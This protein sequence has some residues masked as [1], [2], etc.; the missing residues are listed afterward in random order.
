MATSAIEVL[1]IILSVVSLIIT[2]VGFF[3]SLKFYR[4]GVQLQQLANDALTKL[5]E[6]TQ[7]IQA[8]V[9]G[10][11]QKTL[12]AAIAKNE[13]SVNLEDV[14]DQL[15]IAKKQIVDDAL[16]QIDAAGEN[17]RKRLMEI[18]NTRIEPIKEK[19]ETTKE[20]A[21]DADRN[22]AGLEE[23]TARERKKGVFI[24][25][26]IRRD[27]KDALRRRAASE[28]HTLSQ[29]ITRILRAATENSHEENVS[30]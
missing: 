8:Q 23:L 11:F 26:Y 30:Q 28:H 22:D 2:T 13:L 9:G 10:M 29:E 4:D 14:N 15:E 25:A 3:A 27:L 1:A 20:S 18:V 17:E 5:E 24:G 7:F 21:E 19:V 16:K 12:D 6:K